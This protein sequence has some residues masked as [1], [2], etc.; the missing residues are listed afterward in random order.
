MSGGSVWQMLWPGQ[1]VGE[2]WQADSI[3]IVGVQVGYYR[4][5]SLIKGVYWAAVAHVLY[6]T[7]E[8]LRPIIT[9]YPGQA[10]P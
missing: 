3:R 6:Q 7:Y 1:P 9:M 2:D 5:D 8:D 4:R 10:H